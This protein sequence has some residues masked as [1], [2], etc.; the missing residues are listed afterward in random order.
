MDREQAKEILLR[1]RPG[2]DDTAD[3]QIVEALR[4]LDRDPE[5]AGWFKEQQR[6]DEAV[7]AA[8]RQM[9]VPRRPQAAYSGRTEDRAT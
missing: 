6:A 1:Y 4:L 9:P 5:L 3:P 8:L 2:C 7:R